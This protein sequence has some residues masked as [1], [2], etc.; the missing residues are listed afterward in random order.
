MMRLTRYT[1]SQSVKNERN[2]N[3][4]TN[5]QLLSPPDHETPKGLIDCTPTEYDLIALVNKAERV[6]RSYH[7]DNDYCANRGI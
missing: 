7:D 4:Q 5:Q 1:D 2:Y 3:Y 6:A